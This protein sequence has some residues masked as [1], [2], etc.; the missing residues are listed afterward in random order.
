MTTFEQSPNKF[1]QGPQTIKM[2]PQIEQ[3]VDPVSHLEALEM[4]LN[5]A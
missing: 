1:Q 5:Q 4:K 3:K 2:E